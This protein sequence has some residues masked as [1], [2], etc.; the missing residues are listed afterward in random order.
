[1][2][3]G[4]QIGNVTPDYGGF[5]TD[6]EI[7]RHMLCSQRKK[8]QCASAS[9]GM[10]ACV[11]DVPPALAP[12][13]AAIEASTPYGAAP[14]PMMIARDPMAEVQARAID[15][16]L[17]HDMRI[18]EERQMWFRVI[19]ITLIISII[20]FALSWADQF[21]G[22][23]SGISGGGLLFGAGHHRGKFCSEC[24]GVV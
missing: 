22:G 8:E 15:R 13:L 17:A 14:P 12:T 9:S 18:A 24:G 5:T 7:K 4:Y 19:A 20:L 16:A 23:G 1:M 3:S 11:A 2:S 6:E 10:G 21:F